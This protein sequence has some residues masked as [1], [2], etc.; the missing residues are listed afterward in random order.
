MAE[1]RAPDKRVQVKKDLTGMKFGRL[2]VLG[3]ADDRQDR[4]GRWKAYWECLCE[5]GRTKIARGDSLKDGNVRSCGCLAEEQTKRLVEATKKNPPARKEVGEPVHVKH[6]L[7]GQRFGRWVVIGRGHDRQEPNGKWKPY[8]V[9]KCD[10]GNVREV[11]QHTLR[12]GGSSSCGCLQKEI[13]SKNL[14]AGQVTHGG[15]VRGQA[16][17]LYKIWTDIKKRCNNPNSWAYRWYGGKGVRVCAEWE[18]DYAAFRRW[19]LENGYDPQAEK[20]QCT[21]ERID[22]NGDYCPENCKWIPFKDQAHNK[23]NTVRYSYKG[24][25][26]CLAEWAQ[27]SGMPLSCLTDRIYNR[28]MTIEEALTKPMKRSNKVKG[29]KNNGTSIQE[30]KKVAG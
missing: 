18:K 25:S 30:S 14:K 5:C 27:E 1:I 23:T 22:V 24:K 20:G 8:W 3:R 6:D 17:R 12:R 29:E 13:S 21:I 9:C 15:S 10:C 26:M 2:T 7:L 28:K 4:D 11:D 19:A 16:E